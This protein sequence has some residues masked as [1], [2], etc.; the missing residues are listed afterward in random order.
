MITV[1][2][3]LTMRKFDL[4]ICNPPY[5]RK[6]TD[7]RPV[8]MWVG[9]INKCLDNLENGG[10]LNAIHPSGWRMGSDGRA[11]QLFNR[12]TKENQMHYLS[13]NN[14]QEG[15]KVFNASTSFDW[16]I[17]QK[18][19]KNDTVVID[20][21]GVENRINFENREYLANSM[22]PELDNITK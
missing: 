16:Y 4:V 12:L 7:G 11:G 18:Q 14:V 22:I 17:V 20:F 13:M 10:V 6:N 21:D 15:E 19:T 1:F 2:N 3:G 9:I 5:S 8:N